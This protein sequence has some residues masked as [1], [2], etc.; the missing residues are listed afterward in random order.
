M[1][2]VTEKLLAIGVAVFL[3]LGAIAGGSHS[4]GHHGHAKPAAAR[5]GRNDNEE[6]MP[7]T[8]LGMPECMRAKSAYQ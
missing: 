4:G 6:G 7:I 2:D 8:L 3:P 1:K 5:Q